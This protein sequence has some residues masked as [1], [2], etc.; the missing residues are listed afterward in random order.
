[1][2][3]LPLGR[4]HG[5]PRELS[6]ELASTAGYLFSGLRV[7]ALPASTPGLVYLAALALAAAASMLTAPW[8]VRVSHRLPVRRLRMVFALP[9][10]AIV[11]RML[12]TLW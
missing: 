5:R 10:L 7:A 6:L 8:G 1:M 2:A 12:F 9:L 11:L 3:R 4:R